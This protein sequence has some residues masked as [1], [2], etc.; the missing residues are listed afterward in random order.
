[1]GEKVIKREKQEKKSRIKE[2]F[3]MRLERRNFVPAKL[4]R[5]LL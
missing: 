4:A 5:H 3:I 1:M 2:K